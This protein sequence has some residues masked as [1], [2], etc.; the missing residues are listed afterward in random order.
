MKKIMYAQ[1]GEVGFYKTDCKIPSDAKKLNPDS[2]RYI[3]ADS[4]TTGNHHCVKDQTDLEL[5]EKDGV[6]Y[7]K[8]ETESEV[9]CVDQARHDTIK[10]PAG[11][12][13]IKKSI[14]YDHLLDEVREC[15]D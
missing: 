14:E 8:C 10:L 13:E 11:T 3:V 1:H 5:F 15:I 12:W 4:E 6:L 9:F 7:M 2:G